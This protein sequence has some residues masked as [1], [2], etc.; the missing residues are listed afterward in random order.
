MSGLGELQCFNLEIWLVSNR[1]CEKNKTAFSLLSFLSVIAILIERGRNEKQADSSQQG[2]Y[3]KT[4]NHQA[5]TSPPV[6]NQTIETKGDNNGQDEGKRSETHVPDRLDVIYKI[7]APVIGLITLLTLGA[8]IK[9]IKAIKNIERA[10]IVLKGEPQFPSADVVR[11]TISGE[12][13]QDPYLRFVCTFIN[14]G[15]TPARITGCN[16]QFSLTQK[17]PKRPSYKTASIS[18]P[19]HVPANG[20]FIAPKGEFGPVL[21]VYRGSMSGP[22]KPTQEEFAKIQRGELVCY[23]HC[24]LLYRDTFNHKRETR[25][26]YVWFVPIPSDP[27]DKGFVLGGPNDYNKHT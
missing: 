6:V 12:Q 10:W 24:R 8:V 14:K 16:M 17:L 21:E 26:C 19:E 11:R 18:N 3:E 2:V 20:K 5:S 27:N 9:Q 22:F 4:D 7:S 25:V 13:T 1:L 15:K 23:A